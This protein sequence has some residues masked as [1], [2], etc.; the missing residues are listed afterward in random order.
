MRS[1]TTEMDISDTGG[2]MGPPLQN[3]RGSRRDRSRPVRGHRACPCDAQ[4]RRRTYPIRAA[5]GVGGTRRAGRPQG[6][7]HICLTL[8]FR[9]SGFRRDRP[10]CL[11]G[12]A[13]RTRPSIRRLR[14]LLRV[15]KQKTPSSRVGAL[16]R[17]IEG[18][19]RR[20]PVLCAC[21]CEAQPRRWTYPIRAA[22]G[23]RPYNPARQ[24]L[25]PQSELT[26]IPR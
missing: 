14:R 8:R 24:F 17:R 18:R 10:L 7:R 23:G 1:A 16:A 22:T 26:I 9:F 3:H 21:P 15:K 4:P 12:A 11:S 13:P 25:I 20:T 5:T 6:V 19:R 2:H